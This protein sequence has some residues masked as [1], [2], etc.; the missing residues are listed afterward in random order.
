MRLPR[1]IYPEGS[2]YFFTEGGVNCIIVVIDPPAACGGD[3]LMKGVKALHRNV[4]PP[5]DK[6]GYPK[7]RGDRKYNIAD[8]KA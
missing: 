2:I 6:G 4:L 8:V 5:F 7:G 1:T 3:P